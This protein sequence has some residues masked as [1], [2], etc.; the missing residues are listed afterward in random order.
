MKVISYASADSAGQN[1]MTGELRDH[2][3]VIKQNC[4]RAA[5]QLGRRKHGYRNL[6]PLAKS[7]RVVSGKM[8]VVAQSLAQAKLSLA[9]DSAATH[10]V[11]SGVRA[12]TS[13]R[14][15]EEMGGVSSVSS[16]SVTREIEGGHDAST[17]IPLGV[18]IEAL[19]ID[20]S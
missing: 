5:Q 6:M 8:L 13:I 12:D 1:R 3:Y 4:T 11:R 16:N 20:M 15:E 2:L 19:G 7:T 17:L 10:V 9:L 18:V 14:L